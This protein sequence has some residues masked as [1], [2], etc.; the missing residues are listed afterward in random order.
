MS[1]EPKPISYSPHEI[2]GEI[3]IDNVHHV[4][5]GETEVKCCVG[6]ELYLLGALTPSTL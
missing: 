1:G 6:V 5:R 2:L 3:P 4:A